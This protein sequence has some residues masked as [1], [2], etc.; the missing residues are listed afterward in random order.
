MKS[1]NTILASIVCVA[2][3][4]AC[5]KDDSSKVVPVETK[6]IRNLAAAPT[7]NTTTG[8]PQAPTSRFTLFSLRT[9][10]V[11]ANTDSLT[12]KWDLGFRATTIIVNGGAIRAGRGGVFIHTGLFDELKEVPAS[13]T[14]AVD[15]STTRLAIP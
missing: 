9:G 4:I 15:E 2:T 11:V 3:T 14:F 13:A 5:T 8:Q 7:V 10:E 12:D 6:T 1:A